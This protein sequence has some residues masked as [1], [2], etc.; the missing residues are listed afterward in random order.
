[1]RREQQENENQRLKRNEEE[2]REMDEGRDGEEEPETKGREGDGEEEVNKKHLQLA[3][4][5]RWAHIL[6]YLFIEHRPGC[7]WKRV[8]KKKW[9]HF[10][11]LSPPGRILDF[12]FP[13]SYNFCSGHSLIHN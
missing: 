12:S 6:D 5:I 4:Y 10:S 11:S 3:W 2:K 8:S 13:P 1:M 7:G 9:L